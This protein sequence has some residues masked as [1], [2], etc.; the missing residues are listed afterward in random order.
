MP[1]IIKKQKDQII[2]HLEPVINEY[3]PISK[4]QIVVITDGDQ[5]SLDQHLLTD[6][7]EAKS[8]GLSYYITAELEPSELKI[9]LMRYYIFLSGSYWPGRSNEIG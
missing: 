6:W 8:Q 3:G 1:K 7:K 4:Y 2:I 9:V 5:F